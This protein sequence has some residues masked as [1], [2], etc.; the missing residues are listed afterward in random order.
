MAKIVEKQLLNGEIYY[1]FS[2][3]MW[4]NSKFTKVSKSEMY[5]LD[6]MRLKKVSTESMSYYDRTR[7]AL[8]LKENGNYLGAKK[9]YDRVLEECDDIKLKRN[10]LPSYTS[11]LRKL[12]KPE[13][14]ITIAKE[15]FETYGEMVESAALYTSL[16]GAYCDLSDRIKKRKKANRAMYLSGGCCSQELINV[17]SRIN[18][19]EK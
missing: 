9:I 7:L 15:F 11:L 6:S 4:T 10:I 12:E 3:G 13:E 16:A 14:A 1:L 8:S 2:N 19:M 17:F 18:A 5:Q